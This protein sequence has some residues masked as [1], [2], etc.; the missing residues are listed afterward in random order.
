MQAKK[1]A[2]G[3]GVNSI[4][5][6]KAKMDPVKAKRLFINIKGQFSIKENILL[7]RYDRMVIFF[8]L[9]SIIANITNGIK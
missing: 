5:V 8:I 4:N 1:L 6:D 2:M 3:L 7:I 9:T